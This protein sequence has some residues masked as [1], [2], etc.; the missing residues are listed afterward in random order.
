MQ[1]EIDAV[2]RISAAV[3]ALQSDVDARA[4]RIRSDLR[5]L[6]TALVSRDVM[7]GA[8]AKVAAL[9]FVPTPTPAPTPVPDYV[10]V[11][12]CGT[13]W[14]NGVICYCDKDDP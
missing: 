9:A 12:R 13:R 2:S 6:L 10:K 7:D 11:C 1:K 5:S 3:D 8:S 14:E 4:A